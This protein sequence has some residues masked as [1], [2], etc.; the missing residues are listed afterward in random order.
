M[1]FDLHPAVLK[2]IDRSPLVQPRP[3]MALTPKNHPPTGFAH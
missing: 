3:I 1:K 2:F